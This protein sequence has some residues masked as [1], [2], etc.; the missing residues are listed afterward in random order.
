MKKIRLS[1]TELKHLIN[2]VVLKEQE[3]TPWWAGIVEV[4]PFAKVFKSLKL[5]EKKTK[6]DD[7]T[8]EE[9][10]LAEAI[11][12]SVSLSGKLAKA[13]KGVIKSV[14]LKKAKS[15]AGGLT[16]TAKEVE[17]SDIRRLTRRV[18]S[19]WAP[20][21]D[22]LTAFEDDVALQV[23]TSL[24]PAAPSTVTTAMINDCEQYLLGVPGGNANWIQTTKSMVMGKDCDWLG[25]KYDYFLQAMNNA[26]PGTTSW[27]R[28]KARMAFVECLWGKCLHS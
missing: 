18:M 22:T 12:D 9:I 25:N 10:E 11:A 17:E 2:R 19:E 16:K 7:W 5:I 21:Y 28:K 26:T 3:N 13:L 14:G 15:W 23:D 4:T 20:H 6:N 27:Q 24:Q 8:E 1:E